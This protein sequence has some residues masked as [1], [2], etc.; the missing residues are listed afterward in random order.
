MSNVASPCSGVCRIDARS[1]WCE[2]C[3][4]TID[5]IASWSTLADVDRR[6]IWKLLPARRAER[7]ARAGD[8]ASEPQASDRR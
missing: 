6:R 7:A 8:A 3:H 5:E 2:G 4:R 1:G